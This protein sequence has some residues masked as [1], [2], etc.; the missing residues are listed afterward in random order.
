MTRRISI[1]LLIFNSVSALFG[2]AALIADPTGEWLG[3][4]LQWLEGSPFA[5]FLIPAI[6]LF[7]ILGVGSAL[8]AYSVVSRKKKYYLDIITIGIVL[9]VWI[10]VQVKFIGNFPREV[11]EQKLLVLDR[12]FFEY[13]QE[14]LRPAL[15]VCQVIKTGNSLLAFLH[16]DNKAIGFR[17]VG[18]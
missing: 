13:L 12:E 8:A 4:S 3:M 16:F 15:P 11:D 7:I 14:I 18:V 2:G 9:T 5:D 10:V 6:V 1:I 17:F